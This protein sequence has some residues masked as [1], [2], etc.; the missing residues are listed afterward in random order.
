[1]PTKIIIFERT[2]KDYNQ[3]AILIKTFFSYSCNNIYVLDLYSIK[4]HTAIYSLQQPLETESIF[5]I[6]H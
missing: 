5:V 6:I 4:G 1:M 2:D 3:H